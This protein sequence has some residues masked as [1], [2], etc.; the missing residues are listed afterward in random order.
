MNRNVKL[1]T[2]EIALT[3]CFSAL[4]AVFCLFPIFQIVGFAGRAITMA[5][6][7]APVIGIVLGPHIGVLST[8]I[9][10]LVGLSF[11]HFSPISLT[12]GVVTAFFAGALRLGKRSLCA[13]TYFAL[14]FTFGFYP[15]I[16]PLWLYPQ[17]MW[18]Q[19]L[20]FIILISPLQ[21]FAVKNLNNRTDNSKAFFGFFTTCLVSSLAGQIAGSL[22][23]EVLTWPVF[24]ADVNAWRGIWQLTVWLY[25]VERVI[26][27]FAAALVSLALQKALRAVNLK[28][29]AFG[30]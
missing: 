17:L 28:E 30:C 27:A 23:S 13:F 9:G 11:G 20:G 1:S 24:L 5:A 12:A 21:S 26:I 16:G 15:F 7:I 2:L 10:G 19:A 25:P 22:T 14:L 8:A 3:A 18:F 29:K 6:V 4:Y